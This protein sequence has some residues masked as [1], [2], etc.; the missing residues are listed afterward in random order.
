MESCRLVTLGADVGLVEVVGD[1]SSLFTCGGAAA[2]D[3]ELSGGSKV[4]AEIWRGGG[5][6]EGIVVDWGRGNVCDLLAKGN[7]VSTNLT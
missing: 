2:A 3:D 6:Q 7:K 5:I 1:G 4:D